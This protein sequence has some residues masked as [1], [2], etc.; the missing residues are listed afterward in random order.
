L[1][2]PSMGT[3]SNETTELFRYRDL[4]KLALEYTNFD[5]EKLVKSHLSTR[6]YGI[7]QNDS[8]L[9]VDKAIA[10]KFYIHKFDKAVV[11][12]FRK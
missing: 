4:L 10:V 2:Y 5:G 8:G 9:Y 12:R 11:T 7:F 6:N 1:V 3:C